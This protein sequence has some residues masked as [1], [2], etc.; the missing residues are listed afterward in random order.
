MV[1]LLS[2]EAGKVLLMQIKLLSWDSDFFGVRVGCI[3]LSKATSLTVLQNTLKGGEFDL[4]Y[5]FFEGG[6]DNILRARLHAIGASC[7]DR[8][9]T[10]SKSLNGCSCPSD[11]VVYNGGDRNDLESLSLV[12]SQYSR[13]RRDLRLADKANTMYREWMHA[14]LSRKL[15]DVIFVYWEK[16]VIKGMATVQKNKRFG[17]ASIGLIAVDKDC[18]G[19]GI[20]KRL[21]Q[22]VESSLVGTGIEELEVVTQAENTAAISLYYKCGFVIKSEQDVYHWWR[23]DAC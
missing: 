22:A 2:L 21:M 19:K 10:F 16:H 3:K 18:R 11:I 14:S 4:V 8:K 17:V 6:S 12:S 7:Y 5:I 13:F 15:A 9:L 1:H 23:D 20:G